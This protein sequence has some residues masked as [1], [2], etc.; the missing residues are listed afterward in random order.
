MVEIVRPLTSDNVVDSVG[1]GDVVVRP[2]TQEVKRRRRNASYLKLEGEAI[3]VL[4]RFGCG[5]TPEALVVTTQ[6]FLDPPLSYDV[7]PVPHGHIIGVVS[8]QWQF[9]RSIAY[10]YGEGFHFGRSTSV[11]V[12]DYHVLDIYRLDTIVPCSDLQAR[13]GFRRLIE[14][15]VF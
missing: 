1:S 13:F 14:P 2:A 3:V 6:A 5:P 8:I 10:V 15:H 7:G 11:G 12:V 9:P 4:F